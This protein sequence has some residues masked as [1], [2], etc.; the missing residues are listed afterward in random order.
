M[1]GRSRHLLWLMWLPLLTLCGCADSEPLTT[2]YGKRAGMGEVSVNGTAVLSRMF[3]AKGYRV[4]SSR[5]L[6]HAVRTADVVVWCPNTFELPTER[7]CQFFEAWLAERPARTLVLIGRDYDGA[8]DYWEQLVATER[9]PAEV[10]RLR[11]QLAMRRSE[12]DL[13][14]QAAVRGAPP[15]CPWFTQVPVTPF[16]ARQLGG[17]W[18]DPPVTVTLQVQSALESDAAGFQPLMTADGNDAHRTADQE[19]TGKVGRS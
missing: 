9:A 3:A 16:D 13:Q 4:T 5:F 6:G 15:E 19:R 17:R 10:A 8:V 11:Q 14:R 18:S 2:T 12:V 1:T 7:V